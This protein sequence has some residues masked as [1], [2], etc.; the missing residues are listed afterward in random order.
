MSWGWFVKWIFNTEDNLPET[1]K[2][3]PKPT[4]I[5]KEKT[6]INMSLNLKRTNRRIDYLVVHCTATREGQNIDVNTIRRWHTSKGWSDI[7]YHY[8]IY[9]DGSIHEGRTVSKVGAHV[10]GFNKHS[11]GITYVGGVSRNLAPK[12]TR[13]AAQKKSLVHLLKELKKHHPRAKIQGH[14]DF[15]PDRNNNGIIEPFEW[16]KACPSF[17]AKTEY[18]HL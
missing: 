17:D 8:V 4:I 6:I 14:R 5:D 9:L 10:R 3:K 16:M 15:S 18:K 7:G 2:E 1:K 11:I 12:D 13:T